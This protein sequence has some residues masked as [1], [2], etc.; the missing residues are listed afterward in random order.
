MECH[1][2]ED[3][4]SHSR[5]IAR[6]NL[7]NMQGRL[8]HNI[9]NDR[10]EWGREGVMPAFQLQATPEK[11]RPIPSSLTMQALVTLTFLVRQGSCMYDPFR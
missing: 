1:E 10:N 8:T 2:A 11:V 6:C 3:T 9:Q 5:L 4:P 7:Y